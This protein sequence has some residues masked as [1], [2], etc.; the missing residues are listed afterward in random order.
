DRKSTRL[1]SSH[2]Q[3]SYAVFCLKKKTENVE[4]VLGQLGPLLFDDDRALPVDLVLRV[5]VF[6]DDVVD[7]LRLDAL[8]LGVVDPAG[9]IAM[10]LN[11]A[12]G[13]NP[14]RQIHGANSSYTMNRCSV[15]QSTRSASMVR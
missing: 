6:L 10:G 12:A 9:Q 5:V 2:S 7:G 1:N 3:I 14:L 4:V 15:T 11:R 8:L 13:A